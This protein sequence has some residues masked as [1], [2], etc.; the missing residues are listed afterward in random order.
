MKLRQLAFLVVERTVLLLLL[1]ETKEKLAF[2]EKEMFA[3]FGAAILPVVLPVQK[4]K[5]FL[6]FV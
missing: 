4:K 2:A 6:K 5:I 1:I 3:M